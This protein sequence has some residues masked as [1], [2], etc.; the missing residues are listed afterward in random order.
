MIEPLEMHIKN[1]HKLIGPAWRSL[2]SLP[3]LFRKREQERRAG[4]GPQGPNHGGL[5]SV[6][7]QTLLHLARRFFLLLCVVFDVGP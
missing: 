2:Q 7:I 4:G 3:C 1:V 6:G 5:T